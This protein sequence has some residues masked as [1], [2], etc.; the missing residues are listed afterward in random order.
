MDPRALAIV[1][2]ANGNL[3]SAV[4]ARLSAA[5]MRVARGERTSLRLDDAFETALDLSRGDSAIA[6]FEA[7]TAH[8]GPLVAVVHTVGT[9]R[10]GQS[11]VDAS[12]AVFVE[13]FETNVL[14]TLHVLQA[15]LRIML[16]QKRGRIAVV[17]S[18]DALLGPPNQAAY[19][20]SKAAQLRMVESAAAEAKPH[21]V[22]VN[23]V[24][25][26]TMDTPQNRAAMPNADRSAWLQL[27]DVANVLAHLVSAE[28]TALQGQALRLG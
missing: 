8:A 26:G 13:L 27:D 12:R 1:T 9:Y 17:A 18:A 11:V 3:G 21:G 10:G 14:T 20:A 4:V 19:A 28:S 24:L 16:P 22:G 23:A 2:G 5:G 25:P 6:A 7:L 15:A